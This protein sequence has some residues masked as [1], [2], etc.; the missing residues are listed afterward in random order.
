MTS[1]GEASQML[2]VILWDTWTMPGLTEAITTE[3]ITEIVIKTGTAIA[4]TIIGHKATEALLI[5]DLESW[6]LS[7]AIAPCQSCHQIPCKVWCSLCH[8][9]I[10]QSILLWDW[11]LLCSRVCCITYQALRVLFS[12]VCSLNVLSFI[13]VLIPQL[14]SFPVFPCVQPRNLFSQLCCP[15]FFVDGSQ[16]SSVYPL[17]GSACSFQYMRQKSGYPRQVNVFFLFIRV[18]L[19]SHLPNGK[20]L[21]K[22][23]A[24]RWMTQTNLQMSWASKIRPLLVIRIF[25]VPWS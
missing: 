11:I 10:S 14:C 18:T 22:S 7:L 9:L 4:T 15:V 2:S 17:S 12:A 20:G 13:G 19:S 3:T 23:F 21:G 16:L 8:W 5:R 25:L 24:I 6:V 1:D